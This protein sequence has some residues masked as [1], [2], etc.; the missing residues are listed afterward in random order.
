ML[1]LAIGLAGASGCAYHKGVQLSGQHDECACN[2][3]AYGAGGAYGGEGAYGAAIGDGMSGFEGPILMQP[4]GGYMPPMPTPTGPPP[5][6][7]PVPQAN[8]V[9]YS[10]TGLRKLFSREP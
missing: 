2:D 5:R 9:P 7:V 4:D 6:I 10:P 8:P 3:G 1:A